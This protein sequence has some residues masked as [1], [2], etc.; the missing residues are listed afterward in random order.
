LEGIP[1]AVARRVTETLRVPSIGIGAGPFCDGQVLVTHDI[2]GLHEDLSPK[3]VKRYL[4]ARSLFV[5]AMRRFR[6]EV[7]GG[8]FPAAEHMYG[9]DP[10]TTPD[11][12]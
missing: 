8:T 12:P 6:D 10:P 9:S 3:F 2:L 7:R 11:A 1:A 5:E 4:Q